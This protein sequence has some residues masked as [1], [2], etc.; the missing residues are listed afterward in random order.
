MT[1]FQPYPEMNRNFY[2]ENHIGEAGILNIMKEVWVSNIATWQNNWFEY[3]VDTRFKCGDQQLWKALYS[4]ISP[5]MKKQFNINLIMRNIKF[6]TGIQRQGRKSTIC[7]PIHDGELEQQQAD[8]R[9]QLLSWCYSK[10]KTYQTISTAFES[11]ISSCGLSFVESWLDYRSDPVNGDLKHTHHAM[12]GVFGDPFFQEF[13]LSDASFFWIRKWH[14]KSQ[15]ISMFPHMA[16]EIMR[17]PSAQMR[18]NKF[19]Y[20]PETSMYTRRKDLVAL[21]NF[22]YATTRECECVIDNE[23]GES[24]ELKKG[25]EFDPYLMRFYKGRFD[26]KKQTKWTVNLAQVAGPLV[27]YHGWNP[28][29]IDRYP[30]TPFMAYFEPGFNEWGYRWTSCTRILR[31]PQFLYNRHKIIELDAMESQ[32]N[33]GEIVKE[34]FYK[35]PDEMKKVGQGAIRIAN[36]NADL[37]TDRLAIQVPIVQGERQALTEGL[38]NAVAEVFG[39]NEQAMGMADQDISG[40]V[41]MIRQKSALVG[42][43]DL[44]DHLDRSQQEM[45]ELDL[46]IIEA[47]W[48]EGKIEK[49]LNRAPSE[50]ILSPFVDKFSVAIEAGALTETQRQY[51]ALQVVELIKMGAPIG[52]DYAIKKMNIQGKNELIAY[53]QAAQKQQSDMQQQAFRQEQRNMEVENVTLLSKAESDRAYAKLQFAKVLTDEALAHKELAQADH[54]RTA[55]F[56][57][58]VKSAHELQGMRIDNIHKVVEMVGVVDEIGRRDDEFS[59]SER[60]LNKQ[61]TSKGAV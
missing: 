30:L 36:D 10:D 22:Y 2:L 47:N 38:G 15:L 53:M 21:D 55:S 33:S 57:D 42:K 29:Q 50:G 48:T 20:M 32:I 23:T 34:S 8:D 4:S 31:D 11:V 41:S 6:L 49:I 45:G 24:M 26:I 35:S 9:S 58:L 7:T 59:L 25:M 37:M 3:T 60:Q 40:L 61:V 52:W 18:D 46:A 51:E 19:I 28:L 56:L 43:E 12:P 14:N 13:D 1:R 17:L 16:D 44:F 39:M 54:E 5:S 27:L